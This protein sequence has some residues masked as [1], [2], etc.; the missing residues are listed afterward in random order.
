MTQSRWLLV[1]LAVL[2]FIVAPV[3]A[4]DIDGVEDFAQIFRLGG[5]ER[6]NGPSYTLPPGT[7]I[8]TLPDLDTPANPLEQNSYI[9][10]LEWYHDPNL[11]D[12]S[13][14]A[15]TARNLFCLLNGQGEGCPEPTEGAL[16]PIPRYPEDAAHIW[17]YDPGGAGGIEGSW[18]QVFESPEVDAFTGCVL[19]VDTASANP[20][21]D[22]VVCLF[23]GAE[24]AY[25]ATV[26]IR[27][28]EQCDAGGTNHLY[29]AGLGLFGKVYVL[30]SAGT[31]FTEASSAGATFTEIIGPIFEA[32]LGGG[33]IDEIGV[34]FEE[35][36]LGY[37]SLVCWDPPSGP[38]V[39][40]TAPSGSILDPDGSTHPWVICNEDPA[41]T[42]SP[43]EPYSEFGIDAG[44]NPDAVGLF[45]MTTLMV[46]EPDGDEVE[47][48]CASDINRVEGG[49]VFCTDGTGCDTTVDET[50]YLS[51][52]CSWT[53][54]VSK[55]MYRPS[56]F[57]NDS[58]GSGNGREENAS[59]FG[60]GPY[61]NDGDGFID[62]LYYGMADAAGGPTADNENAELGRIDFRGQVA[63]V[64]PQGSGPTVQVAN[65]EFMKWELMAGVPR[66][67][68]TTDPDT[69]VTPLATLL[70]I[71]MKCTEVPIDSDVGPTNNEIP[72]GSMGCRPV[73]GLGNGLAAFESAD[74]NDGPAQYIWRFAQHQGDLF[75]GIL[76][77]DDGFDIYK[78]NS[79][80]DGVDWQTVT[81]NGFTWGGTNYGVRTMEST[82]A[83]PGVDDPP[84][85]KG[86]WVT[87]PLADPALFVGVA[88]PYGGLVEGGGAQVWMSA[89]GLDYPPVP[90]VGAPDQVLDDELCFAPGDCPPGNGSEDVLFDG[91]ASGDPFAGTIEAYEWWIGN[92]LG[93]C[94]GLAVP[95]ATGAMVTP[96]LASSD[97][98]TDHPWTLRV[99]DNDLNSV[100]LEFSIR[101]WGNAPP[102][103]EVSTVPPAQPN[104]NRDRLYLVDFDG[105]GQESFQLTAR[106]L[107]EE[108]GIET[109]D[110]SFQNVGS[111]LILDTSLLED[112][113]NEFTTTV[114]IQSFSGSPNM[115]LTAI[116]INASTY[117]GSNNS[118]PYRASAGV[119]VQLL[120][121]VDNV[122]EN[123]PPRCGGGLVWTL[124]DTPL[125]YDPNNPQP[126]YPR[127]CADPDELT[128]MTAATLIYQVNL[129]A[130]AADGYL[131]GKTTQ[132][133]QVWT[134]ALT[135]LTY[136][137]E[138]DDTGLDLVFFEAAESTGDP[139]DTDTQDVGLFVRTIECSLPSP[140]IIEEVIGEHPVTSTPREGCI[141]VYAADSEVESN[142][143]FT[144]GEFIVLDNGFTLNT[145]IDLTLEID[146]S[147]IIDG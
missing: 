31:D 80:S 68:V 137:P 138:T 81:D 135:N 133:D 14:Y 147:V 24:G 64:A 75:M 106:C 38:T 55:G 92:G 8:P 25:P 67:T 62:W 50:D 79:D 142:S 17:R 47:Y 90:A 57:F 93:A 34:L 58:I 134:D 78:T 36:D 23:S 16:L 115:D 54:V 27:N 1:V 97:P 87:A 49:S 125:T 60:F 77:L 144:A 107:D 99:T 84:V 110:H 51:H 37:R 59:A 74:D 136:T 22:F 127:L 126:G 112:S 32:L 69:D 21:L 11:A 119:D 9:W 42:A 82:D 111:S 52:S 33:A 2:A 141:G 83:T 117:G 30:N 131:D 98:F 124:K 5:A 121:F 89:V 132:P 105:D 101:V 6:I 10:G 3:Y 45:D 20:I 26:G 70:S 95:D 18:T 114:T 86:P 53:Q 44:L 19:E 13:L 28:L 139:D 15:G 96:N 146:P 88:N 130:S 63:I 128:D 72:E 76:N 35:L 65:S 4:S 94:S 7:F 104:G 129:N 61:D 66:V 29:A 122:A 41:N 120:S 91:T 143:V 100:C 12:P 48:L 108:N 73:S 43:W 116:D 46:K 113:V 56:E 102:F 85:A 140:V 40:C 71:G 123:D 118:N 103:A 145:G 109:C 39:L